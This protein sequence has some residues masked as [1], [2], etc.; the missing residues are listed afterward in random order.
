MDHET[1]LRHALRL[2]RE[3]SADG[4]HGPFGAVVVLEGEVVGEGWNQ[5]VAASDPTAHAEV[6]AIRNA[7]RAVGSHDLKGATLYASC[8]PCP[9]C[10]S[11]IYWARISTVVFA[12]DGKDASE[13]GFDDQHILQELS[14]S[15]EERKIRSSRLLTAEGKRVLEDWGQNPN[16][17]PY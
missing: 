12:A 8:E 13:A 10:L 3:H 1:H 14:L 7:C 11:A 5:V 2:A 6:M 17:I 9:M 4:R 15:R 16:R